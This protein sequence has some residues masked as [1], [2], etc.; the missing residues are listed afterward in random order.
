MRHHIRTS[1]GDSTFFMSNDNVLIPFQGAL[2]GNGASPAIWVIIS[3]PLLNMLRAA[4]NGGYFTEAISKETSHTVGY[5]F[6]D[7]TDLVQFD[8]RDPTMP[9]EETLDKMQ[10]VINRWEGGLKATGGAIVPQKSFVY[11]I[12]FDFDTAGKWSYRKV[13]DIVYEFTVT[14]HNDTTQRLNQLEV[15]EG[16][17]TLGVFLAPDGNNSAAIQHLRQKSEEWG[18]YIKTGHLTKKDAWLATETTIMWSLLYPLPVLTLSEKECNYIMAPVL[19]A[20]L[21]SSSICKNYPRAVTYGPKDEGGLNIPNLY[22]QQGIQRIASITDHIESKDMTGELICTTIE[23]AK[24]EV[25]VERNLFALDYKLYHP[26]V[27]S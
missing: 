18:D 5:A 8:S 2:Q 25:G 6:V 16:R 20:R 26:L 4:G 23:A 19:E 9:E 24:V 7:D 15:S 3:T 27:T 14:N 12:I 13:E 21:Q 22:I 10:D 11:P 1:F 17:C